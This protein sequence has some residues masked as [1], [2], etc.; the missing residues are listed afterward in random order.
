MSESESET[1]TIARLFDPEPVTW[2]LRGDPWLWRALRA[3][4]ED[5]PL[6][7]DA[8]ALE[9]LVQDG[10]EALTGRPWEGEEP[11]VVAA[12]AHGGMS[13]GG[14]APGFWQGVG[15]PLLLRRFRLMSG[16]TD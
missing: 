5:T 16:Q 13:S 8:A 11:F 4:F 15:L 10:F 3:R 1:K 12:F 2:G 6:P 7:E 9:R 14:I